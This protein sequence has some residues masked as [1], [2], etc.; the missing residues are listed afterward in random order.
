[1][2]PGELVHPRFETRLNL[3]SRRILVHLE[4][5]DA[6]DLGELGP[7]LQVPCD[8]A[9][10]AVGWL[11]RSRAIDLIED[12]SGAVQVKLRRPIE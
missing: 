6:V 1:M 5:R 4:T 2:V 9:A 12:R 8:Q 10:L 7:A 3:L 11:A